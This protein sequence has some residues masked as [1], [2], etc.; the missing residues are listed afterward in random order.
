[1]ENSI[2]IVAGATGIFGKNLEDELR[3]IIY[4]SVNIMRH[5]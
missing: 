3:I 1:M 5:V 4:S 2:P